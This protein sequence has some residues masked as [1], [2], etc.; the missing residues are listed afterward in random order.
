MTGDSRALAELLEESQD[1]QADALRPTR[2]ALTE[3]VDTGK[4]PGERDVEANRA[5]HA[6]HRAAL[7]SSFSKTALL[8]AA[9]GAAL[10]GVL[11][12]SA[13]AAS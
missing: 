1:L 10:V 5:F 8:G 6:E 13:G 7:A 4:E 12:S 3:I 9:G 2:D 11:A